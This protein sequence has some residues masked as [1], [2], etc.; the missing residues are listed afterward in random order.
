M[1]KQYG[2]T[3]V[4]LLVVIVVIGV[5]ASITI[6]SYSG[7]NQR[8]VVASLQSDLSTASQQL[9]MF[10]V[11]NASYPTTINCGQADSTTNKCVRTSSSN[12]ISSYDVFNTSPQYF[13]ITEVSGSNTY[14]VTNDSAPSGSHCPWIKGVGSLSSTVYVYYRD[15][16]SN[17]KYSSGSVIGG[18]SLQWR[19]VGSGPSCSSPQCALGV[20]PN[21]SNQWGFLPDNTTDFSLSQ[22][23]PYYPARDA[24]KAIGG[25]LPTITELQSIY[26]SKSSYGTFQNNFYWTSLNSNINAAAAWYVNMTDNNTNTTSKDNAYPIRCV[27]S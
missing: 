14:T 17:D 13:C 9:N 8:A 25:R 23:P 20:D 5:L 6:V 12:S 19:N 10:N 16:N 26:G 4:E 11:D 1:K 24:C 22:T 27:R 21:Y 7:I 3:I 15:L 2:F 18:N